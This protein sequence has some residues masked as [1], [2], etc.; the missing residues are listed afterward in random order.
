MP[1]LVV[2]DAAASEED[3]NCFLTRG[4]VSGMFLVSFYLEL[5]LK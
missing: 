5:D 1:W 2:E 4:M 3:A